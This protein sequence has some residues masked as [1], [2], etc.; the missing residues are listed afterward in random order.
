MVTAVSAADATL[1][2]APPAT[3][4]VTVTFEPTAGMF[5]STIFTPSVTTFAATATVVTYILAGDTPS[6]KLP[7]LYDGRP[8]VMPRRGVIYGGA[9]IYGGTSATAFCCESLRSSID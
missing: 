1:T 3:V 9:V 2:A 7:Q 4:P 5:P 6:G 8:A